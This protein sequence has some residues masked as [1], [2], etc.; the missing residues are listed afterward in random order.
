M[1]SAEGTLEQRGLK[2]PAAMESLG[3]GHVTLN[4]K[5]M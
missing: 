1:A 3:E 5:A 2:E 4:L